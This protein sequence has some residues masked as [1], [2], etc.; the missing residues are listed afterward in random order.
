MRGA[1]FEHSQN[2]SDDAAHRPQLLRRAPIEG[3]RRR[4]EVAEQLVGA[5]DQMDDQGTAH[6]RTAG[7]SIDIPRAPHEEQLEIHELG[8]AVFVR[9]GADPDET[10]AQPPL[11]R[12]E[13]L[14]LQ[15]VERVPGR[16]RL[17][18]EVAREPPAPVVVMTLAAGQI[19]LPLAPVEGGATGIEERLR[20]LVDRDL[21]RQAAR[22]ARDVGGQREQLPPLPGER[23]RLLPVGA[24]EVDA[25][26]ETER[27]SPRGVERRM[28]R[29]DA[30]HARPGIAVAV[31][32]GAAGG[33][34]LPVPR[35]SALE[36]PQHP[37]IGG[38][39]VLHRADL[40]AHEV[41]ARPPLG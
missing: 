31:G 33:A 32:A 29:G 38:V 23:R 7:A 18:N 19:E 41:V 40:A 30:L 5:V 26:L 21:D 22:L 3:R 28:A 25:L 8:G 37:G 35:R 9:F 15:P 10:V 14:P 17:R 24:A 36:H 12:A 6:G 16:V 11:E 27:P 34:G 2:R 39:V 4:Q 1:A 13:P 20:P